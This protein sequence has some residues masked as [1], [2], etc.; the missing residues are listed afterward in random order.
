MKNT[1]VLRF[2]GHEIHFNRIEGDTPGIVFLGG[3]RSDM[4]G[5]K[6][7]ALEEFCKQRG[8]AFVRFDYRGH[9]K[10]SGAF[11]ECTLSH[12]KEDAL[13]VLTRLT[14][15]PQVL[16]GSSMGG[17]L[18]MLLAIEKPRRVAGFIGI[19]AAP[20]FTE[21]LIWEQLTGAQKKELKEKGRI[22]QPS[23][24]GEPYPIT[25][26]LIIDGRKHLLLHRKGIP[27][28]CP[29]RLLHGTSDDDV[30]WQV[31][32]AINEKVGT[33]DVKTILIDNGN[34]RLS[35]PEDIKKL[36]SVTGKLL[37]GLSRTI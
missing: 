30:P 4:T 23:D 9:G 21:R 14:K 17:W 5:V 18:A 7:V 33:L 16:V 15:G 31:S 1:N 34:H 8:Q 2:D 12:W 35:E 6:A 26:Q 11:E 28:Y 24:F 20:D 10:S 27:I 22:Y 19:A 25:A 29:M 3:F 13:M 37:D 32:M 36:L